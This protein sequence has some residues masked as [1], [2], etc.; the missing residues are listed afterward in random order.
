LDIAGPIAVQPLMC[1]VPLL[2]ESRS[3]GFQN[4]ALA[5][6]RLALNSGHWFVISAKGRKRS[7]EEILIKA[8]LHW[9]NGY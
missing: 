2:A 6:F 1:P 8:A 5:Q 3:N 9:E 7:I 4:K